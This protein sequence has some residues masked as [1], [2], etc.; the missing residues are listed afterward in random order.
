MSILTDALKRLLA[1]DQPLTASAFTLNQRT[2]LEQFAHETRL[3]E[4][5]KQGRSTVYR[6]INRQSVINYLRQLHPLDDVSLPAD[7]PSRSR[8]IGTDRNSKIGQT[9]HD[10]WYLLMKAWDSEVVW[11]NDNDAMHPTELTGRFGVAA[12]KISA[13]LSSGH[14]CPELSRRGWQCNRAL[15][16]VENQALFNQCDWLPQDFKG[17]LA[18]YAGQLSEVLLQWLSEQKRTN[19]VILF[20]DYD[21]IG[22]TNY[23]RLAYSLHPDSILH[24]YWLPDWENKLA[25]FGNAEIWLKTRVQF[26]NAFKKLSA[27]NAL[28]ADLI[29]LGHLSQYHG[30]ALEQESIWL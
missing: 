28:N 29:K 21:G 12:L 26:E 19:E 16:F 6:V 17:C 20:P 3:I 5:N 4:L 24:F 27:I 23:A 11:Q 13:G 22:L 8:N 25:K 2:H 1:S 10:C 9:G 14:A 7:I 18:Y 15:L 30:K